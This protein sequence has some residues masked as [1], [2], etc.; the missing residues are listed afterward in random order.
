MTEIL[1][2]IW[3]IISIICILYDINE[4]AGYEVI[5]NKNMNLYEEEFNEESFNLNLKFQ[6]ID[7][8]NSGETKYKSHLSKEKMNYHSKS[9]NI[10]NNFGISS[11]N[12]NKVDSD[13]N[14]RISLNVGE[15][16][17]NIQS[18]NINNFLNN[19]KID[20]KNNN[21][22][23]YRNISNNNIESENGKNNK[24]IDNNNNFSFCEEPI[25]QNFDISKNIISNFLENNSINN[26]GT[27]FLNEKGDN[28]SIISNI[29]I[30]NDDSNHIKK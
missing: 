16:N 14:K 27:F 28:N 17:S 2:F 24:T 7:S 23:S 25:D 5:L 8:N 9:N 19:E 22:D 21:R 20:I 1:L 11:F 29:P 13:K 18:N 15:E 26:N 30:R 6:K 10:N 4:I 12:T 3:H